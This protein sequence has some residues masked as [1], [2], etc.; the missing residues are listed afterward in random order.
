MDCIVA[1]IDVPSTVAHSGEGDVARVSSVL[2]AEQ[3]MLG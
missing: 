2:R 3:N 1:W